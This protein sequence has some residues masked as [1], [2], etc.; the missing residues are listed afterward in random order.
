MDFYGI[1]KKCQI[2]IV[3][4]TYKLN[5]HKRTEHA[6]VNQFLPTADFTPRLPQ[7]SGSFRHSLGLYVTS[8]HHSKLRLGRGQSHI[9][10]ITFTSIVCLGNKSSQWM[11]NC[12]KFPVKRVE[13]RILRMMMQEEALLLNLRRTIRS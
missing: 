11:P 9:E 13:T 7:N 1:S 4:V 3:L 6:A 5:L 10:C 12:I 8:A 2:L